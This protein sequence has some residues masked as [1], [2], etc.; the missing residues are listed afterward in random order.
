MEGRKRQRIL[1]HSSLASIRLTVVRILLVMLLEIPTAAADDEEV[2]ARFVAEEVE[3]DAD[4]P[5]V[6][7]C[8]ELEDI[9]DGVDGFADDVMVIS[10]SK[11][12]I[13]DS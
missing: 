8:E 7:I 12:L 2:V 13:I 5:D 10:F 11:E 9:V 6:V 1:Y 3:A 4:V